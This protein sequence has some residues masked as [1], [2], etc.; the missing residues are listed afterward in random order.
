MAFAYQI[1][2]NLWPPEVNPN[3]TILTE[4]RK[5]ALQIRI[6]G[7]ELGGNDEDAPNLN[8]T[9]LGLHMDS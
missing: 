4:W 6:L 1:A 5:P 9:N 8:G 3:G 7:I 2:R